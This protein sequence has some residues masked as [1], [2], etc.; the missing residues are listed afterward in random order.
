MIYLSFAV[1]GEKSH[2]QV[3]PI[4]PRRPSITHSGET[5][6][7]TAAVGYLWSIEPLQLINDTGNMTGPDINVNQTSC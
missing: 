4:S 5:A 1:A 3:A 7:Q 6:A 2:I